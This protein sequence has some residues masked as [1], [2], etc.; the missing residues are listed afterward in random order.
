MSYY[1]MIMTTTDPN[2]VRRQ[3]LFCFTTTSKGQTNSCCPKTQSMAVLLYLLILFYYEYI[4][5]VRRGHDHMVVGYKATRVIN[6]Y[7][8]WRCEFETRSWRALLD[9]TL[10][11]EVCQWLA[12]ARWFSPVILTLRENIHLSTG[13][14]LVFFMVLNAT[15]HNISLISW[16]SSLLVEGFGITGKNH[17]AVASHW[18]TSSHNVVSIAK[19]P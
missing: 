3:W 10:C 2:W 8:H 6:A 4:V 19:Q 11:D 18:Q 13:F 7:H 14:G 15:F 17:R 1:H 9:T 16:R 5:G 12:T